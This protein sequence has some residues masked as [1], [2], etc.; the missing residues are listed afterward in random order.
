[1]S[2][3]EQIVKTLLTMNAKGRDIIEKYGAAGRPSKEVVEKGS[4][5][6]SQRQKGVG[7]NPT[8]DFQEWPAVL[9]KHPMDEFC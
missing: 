5:P 7:E 6:R 8:V 9:S 3:V 4:G 1:M 2:L